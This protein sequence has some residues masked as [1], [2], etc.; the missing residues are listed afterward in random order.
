MEDSPKIYVASLSDYNSGSL[1]GKW[2]D[3]SQYTSA[4]DLLID[5]DAMLK[6]FGPGREE[7]AIHDFEGFPRSLYSENMSKEKLQ[8]VI[9]LASI[10][11]DISAPM[12]VFYKW[13]ENYHDE[14]SDA[15]D[16]VSKFNDSYLGEY[17]NPKD[18]AH[19]TASEA[20]AS[21]DSGGYMS[22]SVRNKV[23]QFYESML[24]YLDLTDA[25]ARQIAIDMANSEELD[26]DSTY[27]RV[28]EIQQ[29]IENDPTGYF[30][31]MGYS[32]K[33]LVESAINGGFPWMFFDSERYWRDLSLS[34]YD[35]IYFD[36]KYYIFYEY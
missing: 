6:S 12:G 16:A 8:M 20:V 2:F 21:T 10:A 24:N 35:D 5:I 3:L 22:E 34:G 14:F 33:Q 7:W 26:E 23:N 11:N 18:F 28:D 17:D 15:H 29:E 27:Q 31:D 30:I 13:M 1:R 19:D 36:G 25:D 9:D 4:D 32:A